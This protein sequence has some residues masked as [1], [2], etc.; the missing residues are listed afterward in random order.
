MKCC[1]HNWA[2]WYVS[3]RWVYPDFSYYERQIR[4]CQSCGV[5]EVHTETGP[6]VRCRYWEHF[7]AKAGGE[8]NARQ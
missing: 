4:R 8:N 5:T 7:G 2:E 6:D 3:G 1:K